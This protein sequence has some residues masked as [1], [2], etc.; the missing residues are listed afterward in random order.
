MSE[1]CG[2]CLFWYPPFTC[3][4]Y[5]PDSRRSWSQV[6]EGDWCGEYRPERPP[7]P[8]PLVTSKSPSPRPA[9][10]AESRRRIVEKTR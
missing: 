9:L 8:E 1:I 10:M 2:T 6:Y 4:R 5:P 3:R 7:A